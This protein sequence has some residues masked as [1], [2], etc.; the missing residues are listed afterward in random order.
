MSHPE[1]M[2]DSLPLSDDIN[3]PGF[4]LELQGPPQQSVH[5][6]ITVQLPL[7]PGQEGPA[8]AI[9]VEVTQGETLKI[10]TKVVGE[11]SCKDEYL[12]IMGLL[13]NMV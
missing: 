10:D 5:R 13:K 2:L 11:P 7:Y 1:D 4:P 3:G 8:P 12:A 9:E 6:F